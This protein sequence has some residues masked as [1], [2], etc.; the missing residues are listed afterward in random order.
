MTTDDL[1]TPSAERIIALGTGFFGSKA[2]LS[3]VELG[4]FTELAKEPLPLEV[5]R[6][7]IGLHP[8]SARD[9]LD[10]LVAL[11][12]LRREDGRY[13]NTPDTEVFL[14][15]AKPSYIGGMFDLATTRLYRFWGSLTEALRTG[16]P[17]SEIKDGG[18]FF[19][20]FYREPERLQVFMRAMSAMSTG[21]AM[22]IA[23]KFPW[24]RYRTFIDIGCAEGAAPVQVAS[25]HQHL[26]GGGFDLP[27]VAEAFDKYVASSGL[28]DRLRFYPGDFFTDPLPSADV[29]VMG[30]ILHDWDLREKLLLIRK[31][32]DALPTGGALIVYDCII[33]DERRENAFGLLIS[34][35]ML[36][37]NEGGF[38]YTGADCRG[39]LE[40]VGF[41]E[42]YLEPLVGPAS[43]VVGIK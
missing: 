11:G 14:D 32:Y 26:S 15:R 6:D 42:S 37:E 34:L 30:H 27:P 36:I 19:D 23:A 12:M 40:S 35:N 33:D 39:W 4:V 9:F 24:H 43:M 25:S 8:R 5:L 7:R 29:L 2:L 21:P 28:A 16:R 17:Q 20:V 10:A 18:D 22:A 3:A 13:A 31:A 1:A 38:D 41:S